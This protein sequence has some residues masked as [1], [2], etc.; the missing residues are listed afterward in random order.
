M[1]GEVVTMTLGVG[2][3]SL[4]VVVRLHGA[5]RLGALGSVSL[6][7]AQHALQV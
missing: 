5:D 6:R 1:G 2:G 7:V 3:G 4:V